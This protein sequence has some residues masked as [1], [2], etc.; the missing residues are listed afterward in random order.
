[1]KKENRID[2]NKDVH[3]NEREINIIMDQDKGERL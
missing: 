1:M 3:Y 2:K